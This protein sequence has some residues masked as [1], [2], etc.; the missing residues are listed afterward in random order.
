MVQSISVQN[1]SAHLW[2]CTLVRIFF[3]WLIQLS[4]NC[5]HSSIYVNS[6]HNPTIKIASQ[7]AVGLRR[8]LCKAYR[9]TR[10]GIVAYCSQT[11]KQQL[12][13]IETTRVASWWCSQQSKQVLRHNYILFSGSF[14]TCFG[15]HGNLQGGYY[16]YHT[17]ALRV[18]TIVYNSL[19][20]T[21]YKAILHAQLL[22]D[23]K[24][25]LNSLWLTVYCI[26]PRPERVRPMKQ[27]ATVTR[28]CVLSRLRCE[29]NV[30]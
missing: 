29:F 20:C 19:Q 2:M 28:A 18:F 25:Y 15:L 22:V 26:K 9:V 6:S 30:L 3:V 17:D 8:I 27:S 16:E 13:V 11:E 4:P 23:L 21:L 1:E 14:A 24:T 5:N 7:I 12:F 10:V